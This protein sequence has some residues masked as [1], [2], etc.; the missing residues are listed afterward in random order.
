MIQ[1]ID[2]H[3]KDLKIGLLGFRSFLVEE[4]LIKNKITYKFITEE[5]IDN[6]FDIVFGSGVYNIIPEEIINKPKYG[7]FI[8]HE[9]PLPEGRGHAPIQWTIENKR[10]QGIKECFEVFLDEIK[11]GI[12][13]LRKQ[14]GFSSYYKK[15]TSQ[16]SKITSIDNLNGFWE[17]LRMCDNEKYPAFFE[18]DK[19]KIFIKYYLDDNS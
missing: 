13:V 16:D 19:K 1:K 3:F 12:I 6:S 17:E 4:T 18:L 11:E 7:I 8:I 10:Q 14:T 2:K 5:E 15:R 9:S